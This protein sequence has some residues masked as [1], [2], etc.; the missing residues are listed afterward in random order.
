MVLST[1]DLRD[2]KSRPDSAETEM[3]SSLSMQD[4]AQEIDPQ[5]QKIREDADAKFIDQDGKFVKWD[6]KKQ[7][8][9]NASGMMD[10]WESQMLSLARVS[11]YFHIISCNLLDNSNQSTYWIIHFSCILYWIVFIYINHVTECRSTS[12]TSSE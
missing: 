10:N 1:S 5:N 11:F 3:E 7:I 6:G 4:L 9:T 12:I 2:S 8:S